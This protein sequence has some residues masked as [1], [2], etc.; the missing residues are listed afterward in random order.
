[1]LRSVAIIQIPFLLILALNAYPQTE[2]F[3]IKGVLREKGTENAIPFSSIGI[4]NTMLGT[5]ADAKGEFFLRIEE[6]HNHEKLKISCIGYM[7]KTVSIADLKHHQQNIIELTPDVKLLDEVVIKEAPID[8]V[9]IIRYAIESIPKNYSQAPFNLEFYSDLVITE[10]LTQRQFRQE[11]IL[12]GYSQG[13]KSV[14][15]QKIFEITQKR[16]TGENLFANKDIV[17]WPTVDIHQADLI[18]NPYHTGIFNLKYSNE[19]ITKYA[20]VS[21]YDMDTVYNIEY[22]APTPTKKN[23]GYGLVPKI[24]KG[25]IY[26]TTT[27]HAVVKHDIVTDIFTFTI[28]YKKL[29][30]KYFPYFVSAERK[31]QNTNAWTKWHNTITLK[32]IETKNV[33]V[34]D[35]K[36]NE[37]ESLTD[38]KYNENFWNTYYSTDKQ[39]K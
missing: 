13:N 39:Q 5:A 17:D 34:I 19:F 33:K 26:I 20:G 30:E 27:G 36:T 28:I 21:V 11:T 37:F 6:N 10:I 24:Y 1:M 35:Y 2:S 18:E 23:T 25:N 29:E 14:S 4:T 38:V 31:I 9:E 15:A 3:F 7:T 22:Y 12:F 16:T 32:N 8:P